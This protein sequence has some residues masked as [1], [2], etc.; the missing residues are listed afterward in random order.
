MKAK[1]NIGEIVREVRDKRTQTDFADL[2]GIS[3]A[4]LSEIEH[5]KKEPGKKVILKLSKL[6]GFPADKFIR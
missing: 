4:F 1:K 5:N 6:S 3:Q 2:L